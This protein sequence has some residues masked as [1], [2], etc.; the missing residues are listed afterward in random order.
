MYFKLQILYCQYRNTI[1]V[2]FVYVASFHWW[3][4]LC[5]VGHMMPTQGDLYVAPFTD[6]LL[7]MEQMNKVQFW[8]QKSF[9][10]VDLNSMREAAHL[11]YLSQPIKV[12]KHVYSIL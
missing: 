9:Y 5:Y 11:E 6:E 2:C 3:V 12:R 4:F 1:N 7:Y 10:S 8:Q